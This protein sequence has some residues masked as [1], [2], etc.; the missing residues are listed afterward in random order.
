MDNSKINKT[1]VVYSGRF[2]PFHKGHYATYKHLTSKFGADNVYIGTSNKTDNAK[3]PF[4][5]DEKREIMTNMFGI[6]LDKIVQVKNP[7]APAEILNKYDTET[8]AL[9]VVVGEKD[10]ERLGGKYFEKYNGKAEHPY[11]KKGYVYTSPAQP[12]AISGTDVRSWLGIGTEDEKKAKFLKAYPKFDKKIFNLITSKLKLSEDF[13]RGYPSQEDMRRIAKNNKE[14]RKTANTDGN[15]V[16]QPVN[17]TVS[18]I[19]EDMDIFI[20]QYFNEAENPIYKKTF[21][22]K[23]KDGKAKKITV[24]AALHLPK[25]HPAHVQAQKMVGTEPRQVAGKADVKSKPNVASQPG[26]PVLKGQTTQGKIDTDKSKSDTTSSVDGTPTA[27]PKPLS[28]AEL[29]SSAETDSKNSASGKSREALITKISSSVKGWSEKEKEFFKD[30]VHKGNTPIRRSWGEALMNKATGAGHAIVN[31]LKHEAHE[32]KAAAGGVKKLMTGKK[33]DDEDKKAMKAVGIKI[34]IASISGVAFGGLAHGAAAFA[35]HM[36]IE[37]IPHT[38]AEVMAT[39]V[40]KAALF[41]NQEVDD[42]TYLN[43]FA[44]AIAERMQNMEPDLETTS[45]IIDSYNNS[46]LLDKFKSDDNNTETINEVISDSKLHSIAHFIKYATERL[47]LKERP[48]VVLIGGEE[49]AKTNT[50]LGGY[51]TETKEIL[52]AI[53]GRLAAD[54]LRTIAHEMVHRKQDEMGLVTNDVLDGKTGSKIENQANAVAGIMLRD[55]GKINSK[56]Y[57]EGV[58]KL[59][60]GSALSGEDSTADGA[61]IPKGK[62][63]RLAGNDGVNKINPWFNNGGY[64]QMEYPIADAIYGDEDANVLTVRYKS[65][66]LPRFKEKVTKFDK[67]NPKDIIPVEKLK[68]KVPKKLT[69][70]DITLDVNVGDTILTGK[71]KNKKTVVNVIGTD[72]HGMPT[73]N[74]KKVVTFR[75]IKDLN[76]MAKSDEFYTQIMKLYDNG[77]PFTKKKVAVA[78]C[79]DTRATRKEIEDTLEDSDYDTITG[80]ADTLNIK[81]NLSEMA[82]SDLDTVEKYADNQLSPEEIELGKQTDHFFQ[83][84]NDPRNGKEISTAELIGFFKRLGDNKKRFLEFIKQYQQFVVKDTRT[85]INIPFMQQANKLIAKTI[86]RK[87][88]FKSST[89]V[90]VD[91]IHKESKLNESMLLEGGAYGHMSH[92]FDDMNL[93]FGDLKDIITK[94]LEGNLELTREKT[95]G[96][97]L[98]I[99]WKNG[100]LIAARNKGHLANAGANAMGIEE[101]EAKFGGRG[102]L[103]DAYNFAMKDLSAA[104]QSLTNAQRDKIFKEGQCFMNLEVIWP[105]SVNVIP[106]GQA[107]LVFH[108]TTCYNEKGEAISADQSA[109]KI[110]AGMIKQVNAEV[111]S[112][113]TIQGPPV[114]ELPKNTDLEQKKAGYLSK[115]SKLENQFGLSDSNEVANYHA[116]WWGNFI[117]KNAPFEVDKI[118]KDSLIRR[119]GFYDTSFRLNTI[120]NS[121]LKAWAIAHDKM[122]VAKQQKANIKPFEEIFL[123]VGADVLSFM[124]SVLTVNPDSAVRSMKNR[125]KDVADKVRSG[126]DIVMIAKLQSE[127]ERLD[128]LGGIEKIVPTEGIVFVYNGGVYKLTGSFAP[129]N[130]LIN[131]FW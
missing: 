93:T 7:Y 118:T 36:A 124:S 2:Q 129:L 109:A 67:G 102:G 54:I 63:R 107:L 56:I 46:R 71:F 92:P 6:P 59:T 19:V 60:E 87:S 9:I 11:G 76:E 89:P 61:Y 64:T 15:Y 78:V 115:L 66:N 42:S 55:Y 48:K 34:A 117:D 120:A 65:A 96:Q 18:D 72:E 16:Y 12:N 47:K 24:A 131:I 74:G 90:F 125:L 26:Q 103:T 69:K 50:T 10:S 128:K 97:A 31:G 68:P 106:Y 77:G 73:I 62:K 122:N 3:S 29:K 108:N 52:V 45:N 51:N 57:T 82:K 83:R 95:D 27:E 126:G 130:K 104:I 86:M 17:E 98:A 25:E 94:A 41:S 114:V 113:Y 39:G 22:Y 105:E 112:K 8:T 121:E 99:S 32:F 40:G 91:E 100:R 127:L 88:D 85:N 84:L 4:D 28:G 44:A 119:W 49:L 116:A 21:D 37:F 111:Q 38:V 35:K 1:I 20:E 123:G 80:F 58:N 23:T 30:R 13:L 79:A 33:L 110:L 43:I 101:V 81:E 53:D 5:F 14:F 75:H 70:E